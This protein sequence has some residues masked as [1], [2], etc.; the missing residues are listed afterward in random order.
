MQYL[1]RQKLI[2]KLDEIEFYPEFKTNLDEYLPNFIHNCDIELIQML[3]DAGASPNAKDHLDDFL[4]HLLHEYEVT[5][6][7]KGELILSIMKV[8]LKSGADPNIVVMGNYRAYDYAV[9]YNLY[10]VKELLENYG[11]DKQLRE[12]I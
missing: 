7:T 6:T 5:K 8:L 1:P 2:E 9:C 12:Y 3:L 4:F 10:E 11:V